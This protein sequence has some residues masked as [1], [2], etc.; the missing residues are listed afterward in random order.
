M[1]VLENNSDSL[2][3]LYYDEL[4]ATLKQLKFE[5]IPS[6]AQI[7]HE[8]DIKA[9][10]AFIA[11]CTNV[12]LLMIENP[13]HASAEYFLAETEEAAVVR[14]QVWSNPRY[15]EALKT[16]LPLVDS[17]NVF[18]N[19]FLMDVLSFNWMQA[20]L[21]SILNQKRQSSIPRDKQVFPLQLLPRR[22]FIGRK[23]MKV[24]DNRVPLYIHSTSCIFFLPILY[25]D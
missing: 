5:N 12:P 14:R 7:R 19:W 4:S 17:R 16:L 23:H 6:L 18:H 8:F 11:L 22:L 2:I 9:D 13:E 15:I 1:H 24:T 10:Q 21:M 25:F 3:S 20:E